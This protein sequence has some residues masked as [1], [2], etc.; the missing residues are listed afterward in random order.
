MAVWG[1]QP[2]NEQTTRWADW[3]FWEMGLC[4]NKK[5]CSQSMGR[6][7]HRGSRC[8][9][10]VCTAVMASLEAQQAQRWLP[11]PPGSDTSLFQVTLLCY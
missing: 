2:F 7:S 5:N 1:F 3:V 8:W 10:A 4:D 9:A 11:S 6:S